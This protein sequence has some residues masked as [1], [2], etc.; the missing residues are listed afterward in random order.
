MEITV[1][2]VKKVATLASL[3]LEQAEAVHLQQDLSKILNF[4]EQLNNLNLDSIA[5]H[6]GETDSPVV[7]AIEAENSPRLRPDQVKQALNREALLQNA[8]E[9]EEG[10]F[11]V[12]RI[13][14]N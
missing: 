4:V 8:P 13:L 5:S 3:D 2:T 14:D 12:V 7:A 11:R 1:D 9:Q 6:E 10:A